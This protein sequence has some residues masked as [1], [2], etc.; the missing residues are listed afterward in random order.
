MEKISILGSGFGGIAAAIRMRAR[1]ND[2]QLFERLSRLGGRAQVFEKN[3]FIHDAGPTVITAPNLFFELFELLGENLEDHLEFKPLDPWYRFYFTK[4]NTTFDYGPNQEHML[5]QIRE[6]SVKDVD[7]YL[8][9]LKESTKIFELGYEKLASRPFHKLTQMLRYGPDIIRLK[10]YQSVYSFVSRHI[11][12]ENLRQAFSIQ[13]LL[14]G[15]NPFS[16]SSIYSL[17]HALEKKWGIY[18]CMGGTGKIVLEL[19]KL[20]I[21]HGIKI[22]YNHDAERINTKGSRVSSIE[23]TNGKSYNFDKLICNADP[24]QVSTDLLKG[25][26]V[27]LHNRVI[28]K[29]AKHSMGLFVIFFGTKKKY[30]NIAHHTIWMGPRY[31]AL[32]EEIFDKHTLAE[33]FSVYLH[34]PTCTDSS[35]APPNGDSFYALV[36]VPNL[37]GKYN[38]DEIKKEFSMKVLDALNKSIMPELNENVVDIFS[39]TPKDFKKDYRTPFGSGFS[40]APKLLQSAWFRTHNQDDLYKNLF[41]VGAGTHPGAG[42]P[43]VLN[44]A[45]VVENII[46]P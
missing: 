15:G 44:S 10:G 32:L 12:D 46:Y 40:I 45:K 3:G 41:Y 39:M 28:E 38:W 4:N 6:I 16:T 24:L 25:K 26:Q 43:G 19:E 22:F 17:I 27:S 34:R 21:R 30:N 18:F 8:R 20:M 35:F 1:G 42:L 13:P 33:D 7:G 9:M 2:V 23:F 11:K 29:F 5:E 14:V 37:K 36:P 31:K